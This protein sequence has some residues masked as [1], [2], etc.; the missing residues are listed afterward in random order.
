MKYIK[1]VIQLIF[2]L[3]FVIIL[4]ITS[5]T[6][7]VYANNL[8]YLKATV[9]ISICGNGIIDGGED[10]E[11][12]NLNSQTCQSLGFD[13]GDL[14]CD[15]AC[16]FDIF[17]CSYISE[18]AP[19]KTTN[20]ELISMFINEYDINGDGIINV[21]EL[22]PLIKY[23]VEAWRQFLIEDVKQND[24]V[25]TRERCDADNDKKCDLKDFSIILSYVDK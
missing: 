12:E 23:W 18:K 5:K 21:K 20:N 4:L 16:S 7:P 25:E 6:V 10:C 1:G 15:I 3:S 14:T 8:D 13:S 19:T 2:F 24:T 17:N 11:G 9:R 22:F